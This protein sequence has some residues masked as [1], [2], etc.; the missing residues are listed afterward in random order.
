MDDNIVLSF[1]LFLQIILK[2][3]DQAQNDIRNHEK[4]KV[5]QKLWMI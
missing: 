5:Q 1:K 3:K 4:R 2:I